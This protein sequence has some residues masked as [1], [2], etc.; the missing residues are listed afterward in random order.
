MAAVALLILI[1]GALY[2]LSI[3]LA[4]LLF[5]G[6]RLSATDDRLRSDFGSIT[7]IVQ[8]T[9]TRRIQRLRVRDGVLHR[10]MGRQVHPHGHRRGPAGA[11]QH[12][13]P[14]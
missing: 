4:F 7:R 8:T 5:H 11:G 13:R 10:L 1:L 6:F 3:A 9:P 12:A 14:A 2:G